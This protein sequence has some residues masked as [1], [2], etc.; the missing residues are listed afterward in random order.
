MI[1]KRRVIP[2]GFGV[3]QQQELT[4]R[5]PY[6]HGERGLSRPSRFGGA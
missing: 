5:H 4:H 2:G 1:G 3:A 6:W